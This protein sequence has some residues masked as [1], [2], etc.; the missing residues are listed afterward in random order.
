MSPQQVTNETAEHAEPITDTST[1]ISMHT[2][3]ELVAAFNAKV[4]ELAAARAITERA[5][6]TIIAQQ[7]VSTG[8][9]PGLTADHLRFK[10]GVQKF[11]D[12]TRG[13]LEAAY[14]AVQSELCKAAPGTFYVVC[15]LLLL[16]L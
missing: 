1:G 7:M 11:Q 14:A 4:G 6:K 5:A 2:D 3:E 9:F 13:K 8:A 10:P 16:T 12:K 15:V